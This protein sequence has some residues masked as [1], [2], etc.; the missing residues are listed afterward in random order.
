MISA[1]PPFFLPNR[2]DIA[3]LEE[4]VMADVQRPT[5]ITSSKQTTLLVG[6]G[7]IGK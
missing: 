5:V 3:H 2:D 7:G 4:A 6:M 1:L